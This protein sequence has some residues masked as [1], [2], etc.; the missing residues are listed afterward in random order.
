M[1]RQSLGPSGA[2]PVAEEQFRKGF[3]LAK[4]GNID[5]GILAVEA[6]IAVSPEEGRYH[7]LMG[8][9][10]AKKGLYEMAVAEW[11]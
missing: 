9:L 8:T 6:A 4:S 1:E 10:Y 2:N 11:K 3:E 7:D 5:E